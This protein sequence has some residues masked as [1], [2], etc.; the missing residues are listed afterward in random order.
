MA[1]TYVTFT[2]GGFN[3]D[4]T[5]GGVGGLVALYNTM[6]GVGSSDNSANIATMKTHLTTVFGTSQSNHTPNV[7]VIVDTTKISS[8]SLL[9]AVFNQILAQAAG[10]LTA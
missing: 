6:N 5:T 9:R 3:S 8:V 10:T 1:D 2:G 4:T 7:T